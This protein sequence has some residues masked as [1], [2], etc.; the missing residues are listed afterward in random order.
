MVWRCPLLQIPMF[1]HRHKTVLNVGYLFKGWLSQKTVSSWINSWYFYESKF[2]IKRVGLKKASS[3]HVDLLSHILG[4]SAL[5]RHKP[6]DHRH[7]GLQMWRTLD[8]YSLR[9]CLRH[10]G[11]A[12]PNTLRAGMRR[13]CKREI[14]GKDWSTSTIFFLLLLLLLLFLRQWPSTYP[15]LS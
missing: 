11:V 4:P 1:Q 15:W 6:L 9:I 13:G 7:P 10:S 5:V 8:F 12:A 2:I 14:K 3:S